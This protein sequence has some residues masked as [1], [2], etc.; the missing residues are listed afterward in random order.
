MPIALFELGTLFAAFALL[1]YSVVSFFTGAAM[2]T[3]E[4]VRSA[5]EPSLRWFRD[6]SASSREELAD[7][8]MLAASLLGLAAALLHI[9]IFAL[10]FA[11]IAYR[12]RPQVRRIAS[13]EH[14]LL[15]LGSQL[16]AD[17]VSGVVTPIVLAQLLMGNVLMAG[18]SAAI[19]V[20][21]AWPTGGP[22]VKAAGWAPARLGI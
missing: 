14:P 12:S 11:V 13:T 19:V 9:S 8:T 15:A 4:N 18:A 16:S 5:L 17:L 20:S 3:G 1:L 22:G 6:G 7:R 21:L 10:F 2:A